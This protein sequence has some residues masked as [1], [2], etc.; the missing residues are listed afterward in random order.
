MHRW[1]TAADGGGFLISDGSR[2]FSLTDAS[3]DARSEAL[4]AVRKAA[5]RV[6]YAAEVGTDV[7]GP[8]EPLRRAAKKMRRVTLTIRVSQAGAA[9][10]TK[11]KLK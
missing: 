10:K 6:R 11:V 7:L 8:A 4:H 9:G 5:K 1:S 2:C 3:D